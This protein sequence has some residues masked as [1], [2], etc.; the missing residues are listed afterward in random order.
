[1]KSG[2][3]LGGDS[4]FFFFFLPFL[5]LVARA[6]YSLSFS[7]SSLIVILPSSCTQSSHSLL[8]LVIFILA[9]IPLM[10]ES[11][12]L[13]KPFKVVITTS[14]SSTI[15]PKDSNYSLIW[16]TLEKYDGMVFVF[17]IFTPLSWFLKVIIL[18]MFFPSNRLV[19]SSNISFEVFFNILEGSNDPW[20]NQEWSSWIW[21]YPLIRLPLVLW[22]YPWCSLL[23]HIIRG[24]AW[25]CNSI[26]LKFFAPLRFS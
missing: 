6:W 11:H 3:L 16:D 14:A 8:N 5:V 19:S 26:F 22:T 4:W 23:G 10:K 20:Y 13:G 15:S 21:S 17:C 24:W 7:F 18:L 2:G 1:M 12:Y 25:L 9:H